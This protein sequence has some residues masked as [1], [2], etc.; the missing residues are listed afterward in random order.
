M[1]ITLKELRQIVKTIIKEER[2]HES[3]GASY[4]L[5]LKI[6]NGQTFR[7]NDELPGEQDQFSYIIYD[8][9]R[10]N[11]NRNYASMD[12][13]SETQLTFTVELTS[14]P[15]FQTAFKKFLNSKKYDITFTP[16]KG[17][18]LYGEIKK[19]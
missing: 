12:D 8:W 4:F 9:I 3:E 13:E 10:N 5:E 15:D 11:A 19:L 7:F 18:N 2:L 17:T 1:K 14:A 16:P 6:A